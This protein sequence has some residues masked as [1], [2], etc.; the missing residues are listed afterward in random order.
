VGNQPPYS[1]AYLLGL[2]LLGWGFVRNVRVRRLLGMAFAY[3]L[4]FPILPP[5]SRY[6]AVILPLLSLAL[7]GSLAIWNLRRWVLPAIAVLLFL[8]GWLYGLHRIE[9]EGPLPVTAEARDRY[10]AREVPG[11]AALQYLNRVR[12]KRYVVYGVHA[13]NL[14]YYAEG[15]LLGDWNGP[16]SFRRVLP[17]MDVP[18]AFHHRLRE[19]G[20]G[21]LLRFRMDPSSLPRDP[22][23]RRHFRRIY[24]DGSAEIYELSPFSTLPGT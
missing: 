18:E 24:A 9:R 22:R 5:D 23:W 21:Y 11:Y 13:E 3:S 1:P 16:A 17:A 6:L 7:A 10:L 8:P 14:V 20:A 12:G 2:P 4:I 19:V 15:T